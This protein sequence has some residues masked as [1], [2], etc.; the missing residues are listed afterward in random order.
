MSDNLFTCATPD[1][2][3]FRVLDPDLTAA[4]IE[5]SFGSFAVKG[6]EDPD[7]N[8]VHVIWGMQGRFI[9]PRPGIFAAKREGTTFD[10]LP[11]LSGR[12]Q[13]HLPTDVPQWLAQQVNPDDP[14]S[15]LVG[16]PIKLTSR[17]HFQQIMDLRFLWVEGRHIMLARMNHT[18]YAFLTDAYAAAA[19]TEVAITCPNHEWRYTDNQDGVVNGLYRVNVADFY[20]DA[21]PLCGS[22]VKVQL[23]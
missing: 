11:E 19:L 6:Y 12:I 13:L 2:T 18:Y 16:E 4:L 17:I 8:A 23:L 20:R 10:Y 9:F 5:K 3:L 22:Q 14:D 21:C 15:V 1:D 7:F